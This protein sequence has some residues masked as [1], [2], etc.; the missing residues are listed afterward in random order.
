M[1]DLKT[2]VLA[3]V[4]LIFIVRMIT[5]HIY[6]PTIYRG[7]WYKVKIP[8]GWVKEVQEDEVVFKTPKK[9]FLGNPEAFFSIYGYQSRGALFMDLFLPDI[10]ESLAKQDGELLQ[11]GQVKID[12]VVASWTLFRHN[13][14]DLIVWTFYAIDEHNRLTKVQMITKSEY[15]KRYRPVFEE[16]R[17]SIKF[18][19]F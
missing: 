19:K 16:F 1:D 9:D 14:P 11:K 12:G 6:D 13:D 8:E 2:K 7:P 17:D 4:F 18:K 5:S 15:F 10:L 3:L